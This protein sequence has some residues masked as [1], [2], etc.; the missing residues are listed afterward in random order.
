MTWPFVSYCLARTSPSC[1]GTGFS[2]R[3]VN[4]SVLFLGIL[5]KLTVVHLYFEPSIITYSSCF[6]KRVG[7]IDLVRFSDYINW[8]G[9]IDLNYELNNGIVACYL[10]PSPLNCEHLSHL[11]MAFSV[12]LSSDLTS[13]Q[14]TNIFTSQFRFLCIHYTLIEHI[15]QVVF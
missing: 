1:K 14:S 7:D 10:T 8:S 12:Y 5:Y 13:L 3:Q 11:L 2:V 6:G 15:I 9:D 4:G